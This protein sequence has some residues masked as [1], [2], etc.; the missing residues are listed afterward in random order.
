MGEEMRTA[1]SVLR[2]E[3]CSGDLIVDATAGAVSEGKERT[4]DHG[5]FGSQA[6][7]EPRKRTKKH[8]TAHNRW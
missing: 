4:D 3:T 7:S 6:K 2:I 1:F 8:R 5:H